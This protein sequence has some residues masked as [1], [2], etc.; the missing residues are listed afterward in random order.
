M[1]RGRSGGDYGSAAGYGKY[2]RARTSGGDVFV[3]EAM[4]IGA[5]QARVSAPLAR[6]RP[7]ETKYFD[8]CTKVGAGDSHVTIP[9]VLAASS[10]AGCEIDPSHA[11]SDT[12]GCI[13]VV[14]NSAAFNGRVGR[15]IRV[16]KL[17]I[18]G[19]IDVPLQ[20]NQTSADAAGLVRIVLYQ[21]K[22]TGGVQAQAEEVIDNGESCDVMADGLIIHAPQNPSNFGRFRVLWDKTFKLT[23]PP[24]SYDGTNVEQAGYQIPFKINVK[25]DVPINFNQTNG[26][27]VADIV[28]NSFHVIAATTSGLNVSLSYICRMVFE[29][30]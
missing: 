3:P 24:I 15:R 8:T 11:T 7:T 27:T 10:W 1:K 28:D 13:G 12:P 30:A 19:D 20:T 17:R 16:R 6:P 22:Q 25:C 14:L 5:Q 9:S 2:K 4:V 26:G 21:D 29:D 18:R 23:P